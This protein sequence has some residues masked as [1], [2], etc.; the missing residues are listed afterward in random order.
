MTFVVERAKKVLDFSCTLHAFHLFI[1][2]LVGVP[3]Q[4][5]WWIL[6]GV[7]LLVMTL[8]GE[9]LCMRKE[10]REIR[11][12]DLAFSSIQNV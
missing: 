9:F 3:T 12:S 8:L 10:L 2:V 7:S 4:W 5:T 1:T 11:R 6:M